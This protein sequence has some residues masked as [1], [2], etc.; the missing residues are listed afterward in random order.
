VDR[1]PAFL[2]RPLRRSLSRLRGEL[3][4][5]RLV[6]RG[7]QL[8][9]RTYIARRVY[10]DSDYPWLIS[11]GDDS[12]LAPYVVVLAHDA[13][14]A[15]RTGLT[16]VAP[17]VIGKRVFVGVGSTILPGSRIGDNTIIGAG[18]TVSG[19][20]PPNALAV[21]DPA[22]VVSGVELA[23]E[24]HRKAIA[25]APKWPLDGWMEGL[26]ITDERR[27][28]QRQRLAEGVAGYLDCGAKG[29]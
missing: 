2:D 12:G 21:G 27:S 26:G 28:A 15:K 25:T 4:M 19:E 10:L 17:V 7:L 8:G 5:D 1:L 11:V 14:F 3:D 29:P 24:W 6:A 18:S 16:R 13:A 9:E 22:T 20:L 23:V